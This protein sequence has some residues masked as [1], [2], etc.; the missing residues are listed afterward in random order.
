MVTQW[1]D[2]VSYQLK[3]THDFSFLSKYGQVFKVFDDQDSGNICFGVGNGEDKVFVK[4]AGAP[5]VRSNVT[6]QEAVERMKDT[7]QI[8]KDLAHPSLTGLLATEEVGGGLACV[9]EWT[10]AECMGRMYPQSREKFLQLSTADR[11]QVFDDILAFHAHVIKQGYVAIDFYDGCIMYD[12]DKGKTVICDVEFYVKTPYKNTMGR[13]WG[14]SRFMSPEEFTLGATIDEITNVY[15]M[16]ATAFALFGDEHKR[17]RNIEDWKL[18]KE[19]FD[20]AQRAVSGE[21]DNRQQSLAQFITEWKAAH[22]PTNITTS[23]P[24]QK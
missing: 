1:A 17:D 18:S 20:V 7:I 10:N 22:Q 24:I 9:F 12:F 3:E 19:L 8:Y 14:S 23:Q 21:R 16:G 4:F 15:T 13:M 2:G 5:T 11:L 6:P